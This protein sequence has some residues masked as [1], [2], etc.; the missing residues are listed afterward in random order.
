MEFTDL[1]IRRR[2]IYN[3]SASMPITQSDIISLTE[4]ALLQCPTPF[5]SQAGRIFLLFNQE[6]HKLWEHTLAVLT[7]VTPPENFARTQAKIASFSA[8]AGTILYFIDTEVVAA[9]QKQ[10][11]LY[12][13]KFPIWAEQAAGILEYIMWDL[14]A[15]RGVGAS[16][17]H[18]NP[19][20]DDRVRQ[21]FPHPQFWKLNA[22]MPFGGIAAPAE[23]KSYLPLNQRLKI[24]G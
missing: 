2:S 14:L 12:A 19:L 17:Q 7:S 11:P 20:I 18:Y 10:S 8:G 16:L 3:L 1:I 23:E 24:F 15:E 4:Q 6:H 9:Q 22:Q 21:T 13:D 5:N